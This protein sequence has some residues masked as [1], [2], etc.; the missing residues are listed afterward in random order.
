MPTL[1]I[2]RPRRRR[3]R[4]QLTPAQEY[5]GRAAVEVAVPQP[6]RLLLSQKTAPAG[7]DIQ[8]DS[9][10]GHLGFLRLQ[11]ERRAGFYSGARPRYWRRSLA[12]PC[13]GAEWSSKSSSR[14]KPS[15]WFLPTTFL[16][17]SPQRRR[18]AVAAAAATGTSSRRPRENY[19]S[20]RWNRS[21]LQ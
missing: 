7:A 14:T 11:K 19:P 13:W 1:D 16:L 9:G 2:K 6:R 21:R 5:V 4:T 17:C 8:A 18:R 12:L 3:A 10:Q 15:P 20:S